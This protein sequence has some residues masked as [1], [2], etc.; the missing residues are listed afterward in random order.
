M[1]YLERFVAFSML[2]EE[3]SKSMQ[4]IKTAYMKTLGLHSGDAILLAV[5]C[6]HADGLSA[7]ELARACK[8]D[9]AAISRALPALLSKGVI[10]Y[11]EPHPQKRNYKS[12]LVLT[13]RGMDAV[14]QMHDFTIDTVRR[15]SDDISVEEIATFYRVFRTLEKRLNEHAQALEDASEERKEP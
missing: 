2:T 14:N 7:S 5:L 15:T 6:H 1:A 8:L 9:R 4:R 3:S 13:E 12:K 11:L 10:E